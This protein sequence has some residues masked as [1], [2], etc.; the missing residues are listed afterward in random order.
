[1]SS[2]RA[3]SGSR[4][5][6]EVKRFQ[7]TTDPALV[8]GGTS[9]VAAALPAAGSQPGGVREMVSRPALARTHT[10]A[11]KRLHMC[12]CGGAVAQAVY[13]TPVLVLSGF[14]RVRPVF[15][16]YLSCVNRS[17]DFE[18]HRNWLAITHSLPLSQW[19]T[20]TT[21][22]WTLDYPPFFAWFEYGLSQ[23]ALWFD[24]AMLD[25]HNL[26]YAS[27]NTIFFQRASVI[28]ADQL[29]FV[30]TL[31]TFAVDGTSHQA[32]HA[33]LVSILFNFGLFLVDHIHFQ[34]NGFL[35]GILLL[36]LAYMA[37]GQQVM[38]AVLFAAL[39]NFKHIYIYVGPAVFVYL[40]R[41]YC[42]HNKLTL[43]TFDIW[44]FLKLSLVVIFV[45]SMSFSPFY[46]NG[47]INQVVQRLFPFKRGLCHAYW[48]ANI[49]SLYNVIDKVLTHG[50]FTAGLGISLL[51]YFR[52]QVFLTNLLVILV[53]T[54]DHQHSVLP[55]ISPM[56]TF[57]LTLT[58]MLPFLYQLM[59]I[60]TTPARLYE[61]VVLCGLASFMFG[62]HVHEKAI[63]L[64]L[65]PLSVIAFS[66]PI[67]SKSHFLL[68]LS[69]G[70]ALLPLIYTPQGQPTFVLVYL[71]VFTASAS[72]EL[73]YSP[74]FIQ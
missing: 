67:L 70:Y 9:A 68:Q 56:M 3:D 2:V 37:Q 60:R 69:G 33:G 46:Y 26:Y 51:I 55:N 29:L 14:C 32:K 44:R 13:V 35:S 39:I 25:V 71:K 47:Q 22:E 34:Y 24:P 23:A 20:E 19:Y 59:A 66:D 7:V 28:V 21:S 30:A 53:V 1:M 61:A 10:H 73:L 48:A 45:F 62:W 72:W 49:W 11:N 12:G 63:I 27:E 5:E 74:L 15:I 31:K 58:S 57:V 38:G 64:A 40:L 8:P 41:T 42:F 54:D 65:L 43:K 18:V 52:K 6:V 36:S 50:S 17:T 16:D 4:E